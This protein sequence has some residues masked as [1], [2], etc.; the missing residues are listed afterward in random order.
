MTSRKQRGFAAIEMVIALP[1]LML[2]LIMVI[3]IARA[4]IELNTLNKAVRVG[5]RY[6]ATQTDGAGCGP[7]LNQ[8]SNIQKMVAKG[9]LSD[10]AGALLTDMGE[11]DVTVTCSDGVHVI[12]SAAYTFQPKFVSEIPSVGDLPAVSLSIPMNASTIMRLP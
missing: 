11:N 8:T 4:M 2:F 9:S 7:L 6:A 1:V 3:E 12:V 5:A 10:N